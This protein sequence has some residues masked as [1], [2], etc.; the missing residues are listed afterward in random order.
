VRDALEFEGYKVENARTGSET[1]ARICSKSE[2]PELLILDIMMNPGELQGEH[3]KG[4][5]TGVVVLEK[6]RK[7]FGLSAK[8]CPLF[9]SLLLRTTLCKEGSFELGV[10]RVFFKKDFKLS[11][12]VSLIRKKVNPVV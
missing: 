6:I 2:R 4:T 9:A 3:E 11:E 1:L 10:E 5:R 8:M 12:V 7:E